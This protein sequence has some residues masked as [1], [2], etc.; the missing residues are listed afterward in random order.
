MRPVR[1]TLSLLAAGAVVASCNDNPAFPTD[2]HDQ[3]LNVTV[4]FSPDHLATLTELEVE[5]TITDHDGMVVQDFETVTVEVRAEGSDTWRGPE[6]A[7]HADHFSGTHR[8]YS[9]GL[10]D[11]RVAAQAHGADHADVIY[12]HAQP[13]DVER[14]HHESGHFRV[15]MET[16]PGHIHEGEEAVIRF[17]VSEEMGGT[18]TPV[19]GM[20]AEVGVEHSTNGGH[21]AHA[22]GEPE[23]GVY[24]AHHTFTDHGDFE[25][26]LDF[27]DDHGA[28][29]HVAFIVPVSA[30]H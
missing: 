3:D 23:A 27:D 28:H 13:L 10:Y 26:S 15:E 22:A 4:S 30:A 25:V 18:M 9:S 21:S 2:V 14:I 7:A 1:T 16:F 6:L 19:G 17:W 29:H 8:F 24:E 20:T 5:V 11:M 12:E